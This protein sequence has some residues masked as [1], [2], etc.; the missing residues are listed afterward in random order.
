MLSMETTKWYVPGLWQYSGADLSLGISWRLSSIAYCL[1]LPC[2]SGPIS[3]WWCRWLLGSSDDLG[4]WR[5]TC[6]GWILCFWWLVSLWVGHIHREL[7]R[8][9]AFESEAHPLSR[10]EL[11]GSS[12]EVAPYFREWH[13]DPCVSTKAKKNTWMYV[14]ALVRLCDCLD[15]RG[16]T[17]DIGVWWCGN[18]CM[19]ACL[20]LSGG[21]VCSD[22]CECLLL[23]C[24]VTLS[25]CF[26]WFCF[27]WWYVLCFDV[28]CLV[29]ADDVDYQQ[30]L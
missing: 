22:G 21:C 3:L 2:V 6:L 11:H 10:T 23:R 24:A 18:V 13:V 25:V 12:F 26:G 16:P 9:S 28:I 27:K 29:L 30:L 15:G 7:S 20:P 1:I 4:D 14:D 5:G 8:Y 17:N 19:C